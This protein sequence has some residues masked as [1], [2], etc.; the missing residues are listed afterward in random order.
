[1][2]LKKSRRANLEGK[3]PLFI[4]TGALI[5]L[6]F[7]LLAFE[8]QTPYE[9]KS[10]I[11]HD[12][13]VTYIDIDMI[14]LVTPED[15]KKEEIKDPEPPRHTTDQFKQVEDNTV[16]KNETNPEPEVMP[17]PLEDLMGKFKI[18][19]LGK[20]PEPEPEE[21]LRFPDKMPTFRCIKD[22]KKAE[23]ELMAFVKRRIQYPQLAIDNGITGKVFVQF[24]VDRNGSVKNIEVLKGIGYGCDK[25]VIRVLKTLPEWC[26]GY[27]QGKYR[28][29]YFTMPVHF[30]L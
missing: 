25:E 17:N 8:W 23:D 2:E 15:E 12:P 13:D 26:P 24:V 18:V 6:C 3:R 28:D 27:H 29:T 7:S 11:P 30:K 4:L 5:A 20:E 21:I 14:P 22:Q 1:M 10:Y 16:I 9:I 19:D